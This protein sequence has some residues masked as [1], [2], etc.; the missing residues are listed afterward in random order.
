MGCAH[1]CREEVRGPSAHIEIWDHQWGEKAEGEGS[2][3]LHRASLTVILLPQVSGEKERGP[4]THTDMQDLQAERRPTGKEGLLGYTGPEV[5][6]AGPTW[7]D[8]IWTLSRLPLS[9]RLILAPDA[10]APWAGAR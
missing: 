1:V 2:V 7:M 3:G 9:C 10:L 4:S 5:K 8:E 6:G